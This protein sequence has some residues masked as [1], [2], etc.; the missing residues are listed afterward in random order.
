MTLNNSADRARRRITTMRALAVLLLAVSMFSAG[1]SQSAP[2]SAVAHSSPEQSTSTVAEDHEKLQGTWKMDRATFNG[3][4]MMNDVR[5]VFEGDHMTV[6]LGGNYQGGVRAEFQLGMGDSPNTILIKSFDNPLAA[7]GYA[8]GS[9][10][11]IYKLSG[12]NLR[13]CYDMTGRQYPKTFDAGKGTGRM[14]YE[15]TREKTAQH[16]AGG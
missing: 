1:C 11:G 15:F 9:Y 2:A 8:G 13:V 7:Q 14:S 6:V 10:T 4:A 3:Q 12:D 16:A 5:W